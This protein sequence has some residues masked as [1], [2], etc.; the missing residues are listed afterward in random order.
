MP[1]CVHWNL[2]KNNFVML[3]QLETIFEMETKL[4]VNCFDVAKTDNF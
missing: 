1:Q 4:F 3:F 2:L